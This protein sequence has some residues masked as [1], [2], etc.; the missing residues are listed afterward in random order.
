VFIGFELNERQNQGAY[1]K[2]IVECCPVARKINQRA[3]MNSQSFDRRSLRGLQISDQLFDPKGLHG[4]LPGLGGFLD[5]FSGAP[6]RSPIRAVTKAAMH[7]DITS[8]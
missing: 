5:Q 1:R 3:Y 2:P 8:Q 6:S 7:R 4:L